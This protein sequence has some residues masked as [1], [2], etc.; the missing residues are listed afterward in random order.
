[1]NVHSPFSETGQQASAIDQLRN[2]MNDRIVGQPIFVDRLLIALIANGHV[3]LEGA[4]GL[5]KT[6]AV[7]TLAGAIDCDERRVQFTPDLL[8]TDLTGTDVYRPDNGTFEFV[9]GPLFHNLI[10]ADEINRAPAKVQSAL[11]EA[12]AERQIS[13]G[14]QTYKLPELFMVLATQNPIEQEGTYPLPEAQLDRFLMHVRIGYSD[15]EAERR[16]LEI[17]RNEQ[18]SNDGPAKAM[19]HP[20]TIFEWRRDALQ[21]HVAKALATDA[22]LQ[23]ATDNVQNHG[24]MGYTWESDAHLFL[25]RARLLEHGF[26]SRTDHLDA[27]SA[28]WRAAS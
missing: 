7:T 12:M 28:P 9:R 24:G 15:I 22:A 27:R 20:Q 8:P 6:K 21:V 10:L 18:L 4:P 25:K 13:V 17:V 26:G 3:L 23:N 19:V 14:Q 1:M 5:A 2:Y 11:L 16:V